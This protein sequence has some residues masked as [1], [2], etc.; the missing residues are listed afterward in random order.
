MNI[1]NNKKVLVT[2]AG[3][4][5]G[6]NLVA[7]LESAGA[8]VYSLVRKTTSL[9]RLKN[10]KSSSEII[11]A[12]LVD[13]AAIAQHL[14]PIKPHYV[15]HT[16]TARDAINWQSTINTN[17]A[18]I[19]NLFHAVSSP[20][21][22]HFVHCGSSMEYGNIPTPYKED[23]CIKPHTFFGASKAAGTLLLQQLALTQATPIT[24][25]RLFHVYGRMEPHHRLIPTAIKSITNN[26]SLSLTKTNLQH[27]LVY[28]DDVIDA[29]FKAALR[30]NSH[31]EIFNIG[32]GIET[33][34]EKIVD[35]LGTIIGITP[36]IHIGE[37]PARPWD[38]NNWCA[39]ISLAK[40]E[41]HWVPK[42]SWQDGLS[43][44]VDWYKHDKS[45]E[46]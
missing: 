5:I 35:A 11:V 31:G 19:I 10:I 32:T 37:F 16:A 34:N 1:F 17:G 30:E 25:L 41:L 43:K 22:K 44:T 8:Q 24:L 36:K 9:Q 45:Q 20:H 21:L 46:F 13:Y 42:T 28:I 29:C 6:A 12:D 14:A 18:A 3:G 4:F 26:S 40:S 38:R 39:D 23:S 7:A 27:D 2:G 33:S 15:F